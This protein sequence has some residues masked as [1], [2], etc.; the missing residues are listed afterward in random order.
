GDQADALSERLKTAHRHRSSR[1]EKACRHRSPTLRSK[2][3]VQ[4]RVT[5]AEQ[6]SGACHNDRGR[7]PWPPAI[8]KPLCSVGR[9]CL[10]LLEAIGEVPV[11]DGAYQLGSTWALEILERRGEI[12]E[13]GDMR[14]R[15]KLEHEQ[16]QLHRFVVG[17]RGEKNAAHEK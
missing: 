11:D 7:G 15:I 16:P 12:P 10:R 17:Q 2:S 13:G 4:P 1:R 6:R 8:A 3:P 9:R 5:H 14:W